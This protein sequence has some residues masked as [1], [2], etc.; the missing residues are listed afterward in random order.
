MTI[1]NQTIKLYRGDSA[2]LFVAL[3]QADGTAFDPTLNAIIRWRL[4]RTQHSP[5]TAALVR[6]SLGDGI[7]LA[8]VDG[9]DGVNVTL[10]TADTDQVP[11][12]YYHELK[13]WD[14]GDI[15]TAMTGTCV[16]KRAV[17]MGDL[18]RP[19]TGNVALT[20]TL[21]VPTVA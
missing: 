13:I 18:A 19:V 15:A 3:T 10:S 14:D 8:T 12:L 5:E 11:G 21:P 6:K 17:Q 1:T 2:T 7:E 16:V 4:A 20:A 9:V